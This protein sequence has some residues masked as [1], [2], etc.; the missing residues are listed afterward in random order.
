MPP[1]TM[2]SVIGRFPVVI[3]SPE[4]SAITFGGPVERR[5]FIDLTLSQVSG[6]YLE[7][8]LEYRRVLKQR[9]RILTDGRL[10]GTPVAGLIEPW[11]ESLV[12]YGGRIAHRRRLFI[13]DFRAYVRAAYRELVP[14]GED[15]E[16]MYQCGF[17]A[18]GAADAAAMARHMAAALEERRGEEMKRGATL[19]GPHRDEMRLRINGIGVQQFASQGQHKTLLL[20]LKIAEFFFVRE[21]RGETP[22]FLLD[23]V[24]SELDEGRARRI[25]A[26]AAGLGQT[27]ITTTDG[28]VFGASI[29]WGVQN[30]RLTVE[31]GTCRTAS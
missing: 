7:D 25:L 5:K 2:A 27:M 18:E 31:H 26:L 9:N 6:A 21:R 23:D 14:A 17:G 15:P 16:I 29:A 1:E 3:L 10:R 8:L 24:F 28:G 13:D 30:R 11:T 4:N 19:A 20:A 12:R 22:L